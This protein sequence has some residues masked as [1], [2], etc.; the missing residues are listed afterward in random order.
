M[1]NPA[2][3]P[4][5]PDESSKDGAGGE[6]APGSESSLEQRPE[7]GSFMPGDQNH[8]LRL[9]HSAGEG[10]RR[11]AQEIASLVERHFDGV[12]L[13]VNLP[14]DWPRDRYL[15]VLK[16]EANWRA[17][18][19]SAAEIAR[20]AEVTPATVYEW[21]KTYHWPKRDDI[22]KLTAQSVQ[23]ATVLSIA[24]RAKEAARRLREA[25]ELAQAENSSPDGDGVSLPPDVPSLADARDARPITDDDARRAVV[26]EQAT[27]A[28]AQDAIT[29]LFVEQV[30]LIL[31][32]QQEL[33]DFLVEHTRELTQSM[34]D[35]WK[36]Y[37]ATNGKKR[38]AHELIRA[39]VGE[40]VKVMRQLVAMSVQAITLQRRV[41]MLDSNDAGGAAGAGTSDLDN[42]SAP[43]A[44][45]R[46]TYEDILRAAEARG[47]KLTR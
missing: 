39:E 9:A 22:A 15:R 24:M 19:M 1:G 29:N 17:G 38:N 44:V 5:G 26:V 42:V 32:T 21:A 20:C 2:D 30:S 13:G 33:A 12:Q 8:G 11:I 7:S 43:E 14:D 36:T 10:E 27:A 47:E 23:R 4:S 41:W 28:A 16:A 46:G 34:Q 18:I 25:R 37:L 45:Q 6:E 35:V 40:Q 3:E 31:E